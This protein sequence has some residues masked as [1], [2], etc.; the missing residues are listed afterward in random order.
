MEEVYVSWMTQSSLHG[1]IYGVFWN[2]LLI[3][4]L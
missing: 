1:R 3:L 2:K 4:K